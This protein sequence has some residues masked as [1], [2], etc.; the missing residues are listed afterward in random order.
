M[1]Q[2]VKINM[3]FVLIGDELGQIKLAQLDSCYDRKFG[4][5]YDHSN[6]DRR[7]EDDE[8]F[9]RFNL[10]ESPLIDNHTTKSLQ[11]TNSLDR[12]PHR[13]HR[14][15]VIRILDQCLK[16]EPGPSRAITN[17]RP[18]E[19]SYESNL[20]ST[21]RPNNLFLIS[22][23]LGQMFV[24]DTDAIR[25][26]LKLC[27]N[28]EDRMWH[29]FE[30][31]SDLDT[32]DETGLT[33]NPMIQ[34]I[35]YNIGSRGPV[36]GGQPINRTNILVIYQNGDI[37][38]VGIGQ[39]VLQS[40]LKMKRKAI[41]ML[42]LG[43]N[44]DAR[45]VHWRIDGSTG[46]CYIDSDMYIDKDDSL[47]KIFLKDP[48][49]RLDKRNEDT[50]GA[51]LYKE[52]PCSLSRKYNAQE[53]LL[54]NDVVDR[55]YRPDFRESRLLRRPSTQSI[56]FT[57][58]KFALYDASCPDDFD[59]YHSQANH[60]V[61]SYKLN[62]DRLALGGYKYGA[63]VYDVRTQKAI[64]NCRFGSKKN[65][66]PCSSKGEPSMIGDVCWLGGNKAT[67]KLPDMLAT[68]S[69]VD[70][71][72]N[73]YDLRSAKPVFHLDLTYETENK[74]QPY[75]NH[76][77][78]AIFTSLC[79]SG[80]PY[81][82]AVPSQ[83]LVL[84]ST[85]G[86]MIVVDLRFVSKSCRT[87]GRL[88][89]IFGGSIRE[90]RFVTESFETSKVVSC[91]ADRFVRVHKVQTSYTSVISQKLATSVFL[92]SKPTCIQPVCDELTQSYL[93]TVLSRCGSEC[94]LTSNSSDGWSLLGI[95]PQ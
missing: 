74:W 33:T 4:Q 29:G 11:S 46:I 73:V 12:R 92:G 43:Y 83:Q 49:H 15:K 20:D 61:T 38:H 32:S 62:G 6:P 21:D 34:P 71:I 19:C 54:P 86:Q 91:S 1:G 52:P 22:N 72:V 58:K 70:S 13:A 64:Y 81:S 59:R 60:Y 24:C 2:P 67:K 37:Q 47:T 63:R 85:S 42:G 77:P 25:D 3:N 76:H 23:R 57:N 51:N 36:C 30:L 5:D 44:S 94:N 66:M 7:D 89:G 17:I 93:S 27:H 53:R 14:H 80:A 87:M 9:R 35:Y 84:G 8:D 40:S 28:F 79:S 78:G 69:G 56:N 16:N 45:A 95:T 55:M 48:T 10:R 26:R 41:R 39:E 68:C 82:T 75:E 88:S 65:P 50:L 18:I 31:D 90:M